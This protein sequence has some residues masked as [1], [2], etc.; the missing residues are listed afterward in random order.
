MDDA[1]KYARQKGVTVVVGAG[2]G[3]GDDA[4][5]YTPAHVNELITVGATDLNDQRAAISNIGSCIDLFAPIPAG[6][7]TSSATAMVTGTA[8]LFLQLYP[9]ASPAA[10][11]TEIIAKATVGVL[12][13]LGA[14][15]PNRL[16]YSLPPALTAGISGPTVIGPFTSCTWYEVHSGGQPPYSFEWRRNGTL[17]STGTSYSVSGEMYSFSFDL[18]VIDGVGRTAV[19][20]ATITVDPG[21]TELDCY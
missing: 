16:L 7:G 8:A 10:V 17:V 9:T 20:A 13:N 5:D 2:N 6:L 14:G 4:C 21:N 15:S 19:T 12:G 1:A 18:K 11:T 3:S